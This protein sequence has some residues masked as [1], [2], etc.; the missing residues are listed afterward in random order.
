[1]AS[2]RLP[3]PWLM[4]SLGGRF[5]LAISL[6]LILAMAGGGSALYAL[7][8]SSSTLQELAS[9]RLTQ[10]QQGQ[11]LARTALLI[12]HYTEA[13]QNA[14][15]A[16]DVNQTQSQLG[17]SL[18]ALDRVAPRLVA[19]DEHPSRLL[20]LMQTSQDFRA[21]AQIVAQLRR[22]ALH[23]ELDYQ[24]AV[25]QWTS[26]LTQPD[27]RYQPLRD[28]F[29]R[30]QQTR[31][32][33]AISQLREEALA[34]PIHTTLTASLRMSPSVGE[35]SGDPFALRQTLLREQAALT[36]FHA[37]LQ[38]QALKLVDHAG[39]VSDQLTRTYRDK[40]MQLDQQAR[41]QERW[42]AA[43]LVGALLSAV[44]VSRLFLGRHVI[45]RLQ[46]IS[47]ALRDDT[48]YPVQPRVEVSGHDEIADMARAV[49]Q[50]LADRR[51]LAQT[52]AS[53]EE[54]RRRLAAIIEHSADGIVVAEDGRTILLNPAAEQL[55]AWTQDAV[56]GRSV[57]EWIPALSA[58]LL[59]PELDT[60][61]RSY[62]ARRR[63][64][65][66][67]DV[68]M[69]VSH[70]EAGGRRLTIAV[71]R[72]ASVRVE[73]ERQLATARD[74]A[75][76]TV[77][78]QAAFLA[79][80][81]HEIRTPLNAVIGL[82]ELL[83]SQSATDPSDFLAKIHDASQH[84]L[85]LL[86]DVLDFS[87]LEA[88]AMTLERTV[89]SLPALIQQ[90]HDLYAIRALE[91]G[92]DLS[93]DLP[94][95]LPP[96]VWGDSLRLAQVLGNLLSNA[97]KFTTQGTVRLTVLR[98]DMPD[99]Y[100]FEVSDTG[101]GIQPGQLAQLFQPFSQADQSTSRQYGGTGLGLTI[102]NSLAAL[103]GGWIDVQSTPGKGSCFSLELALVPA[104]IGSLPACNTQP[105]EQ[106]LE[107]CRGMRILVV[108]DNPVNQLVACSLLARCGVIA[109]TADSGEM[110]LAE[111]KPG[112]FDL[113]LMDIH[114]PGMDGFETTRRLREQP[115]YR[116]LPIVAMTAAVTV[117]DTARC[118]EAGMDDY[119]A[120][121]FDFRGLVAKL[122][123]WRHQSLSLHDSRIV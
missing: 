75:E 46:R 106:D 57:S 76:A 52:R 30:L 25:A 82:T 59:D 61:P 92:L 47:Q 102:S 99:G 49:E 66:P 95:D 103:M 11:D 3:R 14:T 118:R 43:A 69:T 50:F 80:I 87:K 16:D 1:M 18:E 97:I 37:Q 64:G 70:L 77:R 91:K 72:D 86:N 12:S 117:Q 120:K 55:F 79:N 51:Q 107:A 28:L 85:R 9:Q 53:L 105:S 56:V 83:R 22:S 5:A 2:P 109:V 15:D 36:R 68:E 90:I 42:A 111:I 54:E 7:Q 114:M 112:A 58:P 45:A 31:R 71:V 29:I 39:M 13:L 38:Q 63:D 21:L 40:V 10:M 65:M 93:V 115:E 108:E 123:R 41:W 48:P 67:V 73:T 98:T 6:M 121:P 78:A 74:A 116:H 89:F 24:L 84:L 27:T 94:P 96:A 33:E 122:L 35:S 34:L 81:S 60:H 26:V 100:R 104:P 62:T 113:V 19:A 44:L 88:G 23:T 8:R 20:D 119:L 17:A 101:I 4:R 110:A 32:P